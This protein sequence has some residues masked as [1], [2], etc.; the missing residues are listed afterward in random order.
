[1]PGPDSGTVVASTSLA[2]LAVTEGRS[3]TYAIYAVDLDGQVSDDAGL[4]HLVGT[5]TKIRDAALEPGDE[6]ELRGRV[7]TLS[8][9]GVPSAPVVVQRAPITSPTDFSKTARHAE[10]DG[11]GRFRLTLTPRSGWVYRVAS[12]G[13]VGHG[14]SWSETL[15]AA[16]R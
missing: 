2:D 5:R 14:A 12:T 9:A 10:A 11:D 8:G 3:Y 13:V 1:M 7:T 16:G 6:L 4:T 15:T